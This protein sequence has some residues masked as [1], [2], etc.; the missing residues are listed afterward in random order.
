MAFGGEKM[1]METQVDSESAEFWVLCIV[2]VMYKCDITAAMFRKENLHLEF[3]FVTA[4][5]K[6]LVNHLY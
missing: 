1:N 5:L 4:L 2:N 3:V 6:V